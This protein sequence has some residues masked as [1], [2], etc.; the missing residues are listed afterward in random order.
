MTC[1]PYRDELFSATLGGGTTLNGR[2]VRVADCALG[3]A[4]V[5]YGA[6]SKPHL[7]APCFRGLAAVQRECR[8]TRN[9]GAAALHM[10]YVACGRLA[11]FWQLDLNA[12]DLAAGALLIAEAGG[13]VTDA[14]GEPYSLATRD[15]LATNGNAA[16]RE[17]L[18]ATLRRADALTHDAAEEG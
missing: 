15:V 8:G 3:D 7:Q 12:W 1:Q 13:V 6:S 2:P 4:M 11:A 16:L 18:H 17:A 9:L 14:S 5:A 10:A